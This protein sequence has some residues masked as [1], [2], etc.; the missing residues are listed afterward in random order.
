[1]FCVYYQDV[2]IWL[3]TWLLKGRTLELHLMIKKCTM[4]EEQCACVMPST[5]GNI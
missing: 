4:H 1:M 5:L 3:F 2:E